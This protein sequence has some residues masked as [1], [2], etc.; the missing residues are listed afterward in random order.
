[1]DQLRKDE[2]PFAPLPWDE[3]FR[4]LRMWKEQQETSGP[5]DPSVTA[6]RKQEKADPWAV[7]VA[8][9]ISLR[10]RDEVTITVARRF[11]EVFPSPHALVTAAGNP[12]KREGPDPQKSAEAPPP[13]LADTTTIEKVA[14]L[15]Y[16]AGFY[17]TKARTLIRIAQILVHHHGGLVP[18]S[19]EELLALPGVGRKTANLVLIEAFEQ[20]AICVDTHVHRICNRLGVLS[21]R[22]P[23]ET[24]KI[25]RHILPRTYW[26]E[27]NRLLV[28]FGQRVCTP[29]S[30]RCSSCPLSPWCKRHGVRRSR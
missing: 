14:K 3:T 5:T 6:L 13:P 23:D 28:L 18:A 1:M 26:K 24:E 11:L 2:Q 8:T 25:L 21:S 9:L 29:Q 20:D 30:P 16:P 22:T 10:T 7:L 19:L 4:A 12:K 27:I 17:R 15:L